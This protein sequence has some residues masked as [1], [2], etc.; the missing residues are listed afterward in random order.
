MAHECDVSGT[1][2]TFLKSPISSARAAPEHMGARD[3]YFAPSPAWQQAT[4]RVKDIH[5]SHFYHRIEFDGAASSSSSPLQFVDDG[6][7]NSSFRL[8]G[9]ELLLVFSSISATFS[10]VYSLIIL[11]ARVS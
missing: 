9:V 1:S 11:V 3:H 4:D 8:R 5:D 10:Y 6:E 2:T 7:F